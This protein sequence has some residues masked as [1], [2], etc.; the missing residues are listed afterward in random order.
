MNGGGGP[1]E[2]EKSPF[3]CQKE[4]TNYRKESKR[5][6]GG[7]APKQIS[8]A[9]SKVIELFQDTPSFIGLAGFETNGP[10]G[11]PT[12]VYNNVTKP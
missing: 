11:K 9:T 7:P 10:N 12:F 2:M 6:G 1:R 8:A 4:F 5:T 3:V